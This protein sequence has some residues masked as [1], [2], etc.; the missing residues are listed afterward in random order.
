MA[1]DMTTKEL[2]RRLR[3]IKISYE[4]AACSGSCTCGMKDREG[5]TYHDCLKDARKQ[6]RELFKQINEAA[7]LKQPMG[8][9]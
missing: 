9:S 2:K 5:C 4:A 6:Y 8:Q 3:Q 7:Y 1:G